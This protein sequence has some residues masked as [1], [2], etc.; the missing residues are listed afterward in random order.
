MIFKCP[1]CAEG[2][3]TETAVAKTPEGIVLLCWNGHRFIVDRRRDQVRRL[4]FRPDEQ[5]EDGESQR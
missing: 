5:V 1:D 3:D 2:V 4:E